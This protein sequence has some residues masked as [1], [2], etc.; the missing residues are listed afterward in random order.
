MTIQ[1]LP[2][3]NIVNVRATERDK[4]SDSAIQTQID[5]AEVN[6]ACRAEDLLGLFVRYVPDVCP[7][8]ASGGHTRA[9]SVAVYPCAIN[10]PCAR[11]CVTFPVAMSKRHNR[12]SH[13]CNFIKTNKCPLSGC[14]TKSKT[15]A[16]AVSIV[17]TI[18]P[19]WEYQNRIVLS[20]PV[21]AIQSP[22]GLKA[23]GRPNGPS[24]P[25]SVRS[26]VPSRVSQTLAVPSVLAVTNRLPSGL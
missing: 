16:L 9:G 26:S 7:T 13:V 3:G 17:V 20:V 21:V 18:S 22:S 8:L 24:W 23:T 14:H 1:N 5:F 15:G 10:R 6:A 4:D 2:G 12:K 11:V 19:V 25:V